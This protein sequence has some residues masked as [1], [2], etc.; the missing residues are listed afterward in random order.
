MRPSSVCVISDGCD[1]ELVGGGVAL[2]AGGAEVVGAAVVAG[3]VVFGDA[4]V[5]GVVVVGA[6]LVVVGRVVFGIVLDVDG[7][8]VVVA[9]GAGVLHP[10]SIP[11]IT[12]SPSSAPER[13]LKFILYVPPL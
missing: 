6:A 9:A 12:T 2:V 5:A 7:L 3:A 8:A 11:A 4:L 10:A 13:F 1:E